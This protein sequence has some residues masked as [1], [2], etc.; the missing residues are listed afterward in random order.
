MLVCIVTDGIAVLTSAVKDPS[1]IEENGVAEDHRVVS[2][3]MSKLVL[4]H[5]KIA[6]KVGLRSRCQAADKV[7]ASAGLSRNPNRTEGVFASMDMKTCQILHIGEM[8]NCECTSYKKQAAQLVKDHIPI[9]TYC[10]DCSGRL[11]F[12]GVFCEKALLDGFHAKSHKCSRA[13]RDPKHSMNLSFVA[14]CNTEAFEQLWSKTD[15]LAPVFMK[16]NRRNFRFLLC[17]YAL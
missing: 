5:R 11:G 13:K 2:T 9:R 15:R 1:R 3:P 14:D 4:L 10:H 8:L 16:L 17:S 7:E 6:L 12:E